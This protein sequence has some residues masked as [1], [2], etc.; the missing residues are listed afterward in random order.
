[1]DYVELYGSC[2]KIPGDLLHFMA[3][4]GDWDYFKDLL[5]F[6]N[7]FLLFLWNCMRF[8]RILAFYG[9][10]WNYLK[11]LFGFFTILFEFYCNFLGICVGFYE[12]YGILPIL[13]FFYCGF[14]GI[15]IDDVILM[16]FC[17]SIA[18]DSLRIFGI[19]DGLIHWKENSSKFLS[20][21]QEMKTRTLF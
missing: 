21:N 8:L 9:T 15:F 4:Y 3:F 14:Y 20:I 13:H 10:F 19:L 12:F 16:E 11:D 17:F 18:S 1:M 7:I 2:K 5:R 6:F